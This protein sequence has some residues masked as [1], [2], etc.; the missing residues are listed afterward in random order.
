MPLVYDAGALIAADRADAR[1]ACLHKRALLRGEWPVVP[2]TV[3]A[4]SWRRPSNSL[5]AVLTGCR[6]VDLTEVAAHRIGEL[7][8]ASGTSDV[9]DAHVVLCCVEAGAACVTSDPTDIERLVDAARS[10]RPPLTRERV[11]LVVT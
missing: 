10:M 9:V 11:P 8:A 6:V 4:Q 1:F 2:A 7:L 5:R 3:L